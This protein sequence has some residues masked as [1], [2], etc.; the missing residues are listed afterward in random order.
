MPDQIQRR[1]FD[2]R[3]WC[4]NAPNRGLGDT[5]REQTLSELIRKVGQLI[6]THRPGDD[7]I[8]DAV[9]PATLD[10]F[11]IIR[12][13]RQGRHT[14]NGRQH[15]IFG[16]A[17]VVVG[18]ELQRD[19]RVAFCRTRCRLGDPIQALKRRLKNLNNRRVDVFGPGAVPRHTDGHVVRNHIR[20]ELRPHLRDRVETYGD[21]QHQEQIGRGPMPGEVAEDP[22]C[23]PGQVT[24]HGQGS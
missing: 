5:L 2:D 16:P 1:H 9:R 4:G 3:L 10:D 22:E 19:P 13:I 12:V 24:R 17:H 8:S 6:D 21:Q 7:D 15:I 11:G 14:V 23:G 18:L 20:K